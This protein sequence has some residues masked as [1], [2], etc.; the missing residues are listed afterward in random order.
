MEGVELCTR[1]CVCMWIP[2]EE[3]EE[4]EEALTGGLKEEMT[5]E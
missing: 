1:S 3:E 2:R 5:L 4:V